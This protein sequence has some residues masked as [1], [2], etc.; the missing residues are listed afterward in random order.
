MRAL[1]AEPD[2]G[3]RSHLHAALSQRG[4]RVTVVPSGDAAIAAFLA[5]PFPLVVLSSQLADTGGPGVCRAIRNTTVGRAAYLL[6]TLPMAAPEAMRPLV[7]AGAD[8]F[9]TVPLIP[10]QVAMRLAFAEYRLAMHPDEE[11]EGEAPA[12]SYQERIAEL[13]HEIRVQQQSLAESESRYRALFDQSPVGVFLCDTELRVTHC[14][15]SLATITGVAEEGVVG[16]RVSGPD[17]GA[18]LPWL[19]DAAQ[20]A[21]FEGPYRTDGREDR[22]WISVRYAPLRDGEERLVGGI[23][24]VED[25]TDRERAEERL[26]AQATELEVVNAAL[27]ERTRELESAMQART[28]LYTSM[29]HE[30]RTP[31]SAIMLYQELLL[32]GALGEL[33]AEQREAVANSHTAAEHL[34]ELVRDILDLSKIE[35][36]KMEVNPVEVELPTLVR[37][38]LA[39]VHPLTQRYGSEIRLESQEELPRLVTDPQRVRQVLLNLISNAARFGRSRPITIRCRRISEEETAVEVEDQGIGIGDADLQEIFE[40]FVQVGKIQEGGTGLGLAISRRLARLLDGRLE[41]ESEPDVGSVFRLI[42]PLAA[43]SIPVPQEQ[44]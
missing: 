33:S 17:A 32:A 39:T 19:L 7:E 14:N 44:R 38:L 37:D 18:L 43:P 41:V 16:R 15:G 35:A 11:D 21:L 5:S 30:L 13:E 2:S 20:P 42:L 25:I 34:L 10:S 4:W 36:G 9:L 24:V 27:H 23:G 28:R 12:L 31:I 29:N 6:A 26:R 1:L 8:D 40:E 3:V 22:R